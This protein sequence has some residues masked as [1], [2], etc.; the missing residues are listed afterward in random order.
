MKALFFGEDANKIEQLAL[1]LRIRWPELESIMVTR[2]R[3]GLMAVEQQ[4]PDIVFICEDLP[5]M[6]RYTAIAEIRKFSD[7]P[8]V[9]WTDDD[10]MQGVKVLDHGGDD[11]FTPST[12]MMV[13]VVKVV[14]IMRRAGLVNRKSDESPIQCGDLHIDPGTYEV[15][16]G[17]NNLHLTPT[18]FRLLHLLAKNRHITLSQAYILDAVWAEDMDGGNKVKKY[19]QR[20]RRKM[21]DDAKNPRWIKTVHGMG[22]RLNA[23]LPEESLATFEAA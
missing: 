15:Y 1:A 19:I 18:E 9:A 2:G 4:G 5:D 7:I 14:A 16:L 22:Y 10:E 23:P 21:E 20:L 11:Y 12:N 6:N 17:E 3:H 8:I 13:M